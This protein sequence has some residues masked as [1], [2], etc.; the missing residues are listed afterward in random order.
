MQELTAVAAL[1]EEQT[2][3]V[4]VPAAA[5]AEGRVNCKIHASPSGR[6]DVVD[7]ELR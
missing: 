7:P 3:A 1:A 5:V 4:A 2:V 6:Y